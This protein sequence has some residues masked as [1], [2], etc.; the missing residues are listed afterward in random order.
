M[1]G[2][3]KKSG[4]LFWD[5]YLDDRWIGMVLGEMVGDA[6]KYAYLHF[7]NVGRERLTVKRY[8]KV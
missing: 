6:L 1:F 3:R 2:R 8:G 4:L 7:P 5:L